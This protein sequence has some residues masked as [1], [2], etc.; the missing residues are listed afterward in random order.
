MRLK[1]VV[2]LA[3]LILFIP[4]PFTSLMTI[5]LGDDGR[6]DSL[7]FLLLLRDG[8]GVCIRIGIQ[9]RAALRDGFNDL[10]LLLGLKLVAQ[11]LVSPG[12]FRRCPHRV[13][14]VV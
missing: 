10:L 4:L 13:E 8:L 5:M 9:P 7:H 1:L 12:A 3:L 11:S 14:I 2:H 6:A